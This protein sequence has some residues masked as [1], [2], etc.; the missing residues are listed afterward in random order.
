M[1]QRSL[2][3]IS[4]WREK[5]GE[6]NKRWSEFLLFTWAGWRPIGIVGIGVFF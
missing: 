2:T 5:R 1:F 6:S 3:E 4:L